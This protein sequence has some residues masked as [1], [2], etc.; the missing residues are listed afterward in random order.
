MGAW[1]EPQSAFRPETLSAFDQIF[2]EVWDELLADGTF[3]ALDTG[4]T[5][6]RLAQKVLAFASN[7]WTEIQIKQ[8]LLRAFRNEAARQQRIRRPQLVVDARPK[9]T[10]AASVIS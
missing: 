9:R 5:R 3:R 10:T 8:L 4:R 1:R 7:G 2:D 6:T